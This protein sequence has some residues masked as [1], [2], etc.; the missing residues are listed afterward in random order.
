MRIKHT[1]VYEGVTPEIWFACGAAHVLFRRHGYIVTAESMI[2]SR[3]PASMHSK[4]L[5]V[6]LSLSGVKPEHVTE[7]FADLHAILSRLGYSV[8]LMIDGDHIHVEF[9]PEEG[10]SWLTETA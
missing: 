6:D 5:A 8:V 10:E 3:R 7:I 9:N 1:A 2:D 4:G